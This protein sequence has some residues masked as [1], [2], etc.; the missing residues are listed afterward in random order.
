[1]KSSMKRNWVWLIILLNGF[2]ALYAQGAN[3]DFEFKLNY[4][5]F[6]GGMN[7]FSNGYAVAL[8]A[9]LFNFFVEHDRTNIGLELSPL[10]YKANNAY[11]KLEWDQNLY[12][13]NGNLYWNP[14]DIEHIILGPFVAI[15]YLSVENWSKFNADNYVFSAGLRFLLRT[16]LKDWNYPFQIIG[17]EAGY[18]TISGKHSFYFTVSLDIGVLAWLTALTLMAEGADVIEANEDY[19]RQIN[20]TGPF[21]PKEPKQ[22]K[23]PFQN[24]REID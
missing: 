16:Y 12:F 1:M 7:L 3:N 10:N 14:F 2:F 17:S 6:S 8:S 4:G 18:R 22:P 11:D 5:S 19:E 21:V 9:G 20:G 13:L 15:N 24:D 23:L